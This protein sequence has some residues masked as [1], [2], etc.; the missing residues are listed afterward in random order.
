MV[1][2]ENLSGIGS[3]RGRGEEQMKKAA[4]KDRGESK[5]QREAVKASERQN[6]YNICEDLSRNSKVSAPTSLEN[7]WWNRR[8]I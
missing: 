6:S 2:G 7:C 4:Q 8:I 5:E 3:E 1:V